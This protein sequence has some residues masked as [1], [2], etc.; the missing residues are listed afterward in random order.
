[1]PSPPRREA[2]E[3]ELLTAFGQLGEA[4]MATEVLNERSLA[5]MK[6]MSDKLT[7][8]DF[9]QVG[10]KAWFLLVISAVRTYK[11]TH[12]CM[13]ILFQVCQSHPPPPSR[14]GEGVLCFG[15]CCLSL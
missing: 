11:Y 5:V 8:R 4:N 2:R 14:G 13:L 12:L 3:R 9:L 1:M 7:G 15:F 6:R 10:L